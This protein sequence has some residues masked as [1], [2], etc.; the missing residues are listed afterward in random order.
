MGRWWRD[1]KVSSLI[2]GGLACGRDRQTT[3]GSQT[4]RGGPP[5]CP[6]SGWNA[7]VVL[8][9]HCQPLVFSPSWCELLFQNGPG[10]PQQSLAIVHPVFCFCVGVFVNMLVLALVFHQFL[11]AQCRIG[12]GWVAAWPQMRSGW[13]PLSAVCGQRSSCTMETGRP[14]WVWDGNT[15][16][17][18]PTHGRY[19]LYRQCSWPDSL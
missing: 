14:L 1:R 3:D 8:F 15:H 6:S 5:G 7:T 12:F 19:Q 2:Q 13:R 11:Q 17:R 10:V 16:T 18:S 4:H 9:H